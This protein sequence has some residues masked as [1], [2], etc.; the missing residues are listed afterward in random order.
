MRLS[1]CL[2]VLLS[3]ATVAAK[4]PNPNKVKVGCFAVHCAGEMLKAIVDPLFTK[5]L[6]PCIQGCNCLYSNDTDPQ[7]LSFV[8]CTTKCAFT[9]QSKPAQNFMS[10]AQQHKCMSFAPINVTCPVPKSK[11]NTGLEVFVGHKWRQEYGWNKLFDAYPCQQIHNVSLSNNATFCSQQ[12]RPDGTSIEAPC[13]HYDYSYD[14]FTETG[15]YHQRQVWQLPGNVPKGDPVEIFYTYAGSL[16]NETWWIIDANDRYVLLFDC[17]KM[18]GWTLSG[19]IVWVNAAIGKLTPDDLKAIGA[20]YAAAGFPES[21]GGQG[22]S[23][24]NDFLQDRWAT[25]CSPIDSRGVITDKNR[26]ITDKNYKQRLTEAQF[27]MAA[28]WR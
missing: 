20:S 28:L 19:S 7:R 1:V 2:L 22:W 12:L 24:P 23:F 17:S 8:N 25:G 4:C 6:M 26:V 9:Y 16:H 15:L 14:V 5:Q 18:S 10:C 27:E 11:P 13:W 3:L 21:T